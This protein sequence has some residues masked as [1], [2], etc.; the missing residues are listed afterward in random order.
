M[1][2][3]DRCVTP[4]LPSGGF[5]AGFGFGGY[6]VIYSAVAISRK[7]LPKIFNDIYGIG[8]AGTA[9]LAQLVGLVDLNALG[10]GSYD[11]MEQTNWRVKP[12]RVLNRISVLGTTSGPFNIMRAFG[13]PGTISPAVA[14]AHLV[15]IGG[16]CVLEYSDPDSWE[17]APKSV[18]ALANA[19]K[20]TM[21]E[22][23]AWVGNAF[24]IL[25]FPSMLGISFSATT[26]AGTLSAVLILEI[27]TRV[28]VNYFYDSDK[29]AQDAFREG[30]FVNRDDAESGP[31]DD[32]SY[33]TQASLKAQ[34]VLGFFRERVLGP[35]GNSLAAQNLATL[36]PTL[37]FDVMLK[38]MGKKAGF[39]A[40]VLTSGAVYVYKEGFERCLRSRQTPNN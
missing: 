36:S 13:K 6:M 16:T 20:Q 40:A 19:T 35:A 21:H 3:Q 25:L 22:G 28:P 34:R 32:P 10:H 27:A 11:T 4:N 14:T 30:K 18:R 33:C 1:Q 39:V 31:H 5:V 15:L 37:L 2:T 9:G 29:E 17:R 7:E 8:F 12:T 24:A 38:G 26:A 23:G